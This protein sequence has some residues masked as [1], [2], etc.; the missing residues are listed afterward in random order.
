MVTYPKEWK[1]ISIGTIFSTI[2]DYVAAGSFAALAN[3]V[4]YLSTPNYA[5][6]IRTR[7]IKAKYANRD[8][9]YID[10]EAYDF[11]WRVHFDSPKIIMPNIGNCGE[12]YYVLPNELPSPRCA[13]GPNA[14]MLSNTNS[15]LEFLSYVLTR[16]DF[17]NNLKD[18]T[19][20]SGQTKFNKTDLAKLVITIPRRLDEQQAIAETLSAFDE[21]LENLTKL[22][23]KKRA[24]RDGALEDLV[25]GK[26]RLEGFKCE[27]VDCKIGNILTILH[28]KNQHSIESHHGKYPIL[29]TGGIIGRT[30][31]FLCDWAC[32]LIGRKGTIDNP[33]YM[34]EPFWTIDTLYY[35][36]PKPNHDPKFQ[37]YLFCTIDWHEYT[38]S[39]GRPS[40]AK[41]VIEA[42]EIK[43]PKLEE[44]KAI[45]SILTAMD[46][47]LIKLEHE[48]EKI[49]Q[50]KEGAMDDLLTG[51]IRL[52]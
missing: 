40:L 45:A 38:E 23:E 17:Q 20:P 28:G 18:I 52:V 41:D 7:D 3:N 10:K 24:I 33:M 35:S 9:V 1:E 22:I 19:S 48:R 50:I 21:H 13:L 31:T 44:Q 27:W 37:Y 30:D 46:D 5:Q 49:Q 26:T 2:T 4:R 51:N 15:N 14:I 29:G 6:L 34:S 47:E 43:V 32:V 36:R 12:V 11:L 8:F 16:S 42:I 39:S 25:T